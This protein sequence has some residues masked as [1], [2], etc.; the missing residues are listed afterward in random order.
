MSATKKHAKV[1]RRMES[2][3]PRLIVPLEA[4]SFSGC[5]PEEPVLMAVPDHKNDFTGR[6]AYVWV[7]DDKV[8]G[9]FGT[10]PVA[11]FLALADAI[12]R[13]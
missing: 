1:E 2:N 10:I 12:R 13:G 6:Q 4:P 5:K 7:G 11:R 8:T 9:C 3:G